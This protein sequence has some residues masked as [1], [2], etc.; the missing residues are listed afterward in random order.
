[1]QWQISSV[2]CSKSINYTVTTTVVRENFF[3]MIGPNLIH[4]NDVEPWRRDAPPPRGVRFSRRMWLIEN[5]NDSTDSQV[6][7]IVDERQTNVLGP[8]GGWTG[9]LV[10][11]GQVDPA[12][13]ALAHLEDFQS[14][15]QVQVISTALKVGTR[16][17]LLVQRV[18]QIISVFVAYLAKHSLTL[19]IIIFQ[20]WANPASFSFIFCL[21]QTHITIFTTNKCEKCPS[22]I[23][24]QDSNSRPLG[25][26]SPPITTTPV[27]LLKI[28]K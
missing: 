14:L 28:I 20:K 9:Q 1:M 15:I 22:S 26:E 21:F 11:E 25:H 6:L 16:R 13:Q 4:K 12:V 7:V 10:T 19:K 23:R 8:D 17:F 27:H 3:I 24:C 18:L 5:L 2:K